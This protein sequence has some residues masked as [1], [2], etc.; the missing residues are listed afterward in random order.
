MNNKVQVHVA[1]THPTHL[2]VTLLPLQA[3]RRL[4]QNSARCK[5]LGV[6]SLSITTSVQFTGM[7]ATCGVY[8]VFT[9]ST[10]QT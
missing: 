1:T 6:D 3:A 7:P 9:F 4:P 10:A 5:R 2:F 8:G